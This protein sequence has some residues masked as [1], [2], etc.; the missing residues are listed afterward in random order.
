[1]LAMSTI[2]ERRTPFKICLGHGTVLAEDGRQMHKSWGNAI[3]F[4]DAAETMGADVMRW[5]FSSNIPEKDILF[6]YNKAGEVKRFFFMPVLNIYNFFAMYA[7]LDKWTPDQQPETLSELDRWILSRLNQ[8]VKV[9][10]DSLDSF[11]AL[12]AT[13]ET[14][15]FV[16]E[17]STWYV[18]R[19]RRRFWKSEANDDK[20]AA[21]STLYTCLKTLTHLIAPFIPFL[22][23]EIYQKLVRSVEK[24]S[25]ESLHLSS[26]PVV[27][28]SLIDKDLMAKMDLAIKA[29]SIGR[30]AR[31]NS[32]VKKLRQP[33]QE[34]LFL[35]NNT[36][37]ERLEDLS[38]LIMEELNVKQVRF[39]SEASELQSYKLKPVRSLLGRKH[40]RNLMKVVQ[41]IETLGKRDITMLVNGENVTV[42]V[43]D[44]P[45]EILAEEVHAES[46]PV[47]GYS[48]ISEGG[49]TVGIKTEI[50]EELAREGLARDIVR[51]IQ[52][53]RKLADFNI[54]D[55]IETWYSGD[56]K[57]LEVFKTERE[58]ITSETL[59]Q[60]L[61][62][63]DPPSNAKI[64][65]LDI[66][67][68]KVKLGVRK[69]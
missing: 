62:H 2:L 69:I 29:C 3:W 47:E 17:L 54:D 21:Y 31:N 43:D 45:V 33:M 14:E 13:H 25:V 7:K 26:W 49:L 66:D 53:L 10:T 60:I 44:S 8:L 48:V 19:S 9:A 50:T 46:L 32:S 64:Q 20:K 30:A 22:S 5:M 27:D 12:I 56:E 18:R 24:E 51:R 1:M 40:G 34:A 58:Y 61:N 4:D 41:V 52:D 39:T 37:K 42:N 6:G 35:A 65:E 36:M 55:K 38:D 67:G 11:S 16:D 63:G 57:I 28:E 68:Q 15:K 59:T 23:E